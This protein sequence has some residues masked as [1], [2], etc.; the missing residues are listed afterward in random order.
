MEN[1]MNISINGKGAFVVAELRGFEVD[2]F[3]DD[4]KKV[5]HYGSFFIDCGSTGETFKLKMNSEFIQ[6]AQNISALE[7]LKGKLCIFPI[8]LGTNQS[9]F[10]TVRFGGRNLPKLI[11]NTNG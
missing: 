3:T 1:N 9:G 11:E 4:N 8:D 2:S 7:K 10:P 5:I 6:Q